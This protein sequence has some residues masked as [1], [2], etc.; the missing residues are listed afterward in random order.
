M[1]IYNASMYAC[2]YNYVSCQAC[3]YLC[4]IMRFHYYNVI[5]LFSELPFFLNS[6]ISKIMEIGKFGI[7][8]LQKVRNSMFQEMWKFQK[9]GILLFLEYHYFCFGIA[10]L[11][12]M[13]LCMYI[14]T[15]I[16][17]YWFI[18]VCLDT[19]TYRCMHMYAFI[20]IYVSTH[21][22]ACLICVYM[23]IC[24]HVLHMYMNVC[25]M[26]MYILTHIHSSMPVY[27]HTHMSVHAYVC[28]VCVYTYTCIYACI[29]MYV[30][31]VSMCV[32]YV[33]MYIKE[34][35]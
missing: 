16:H 3:M 6:A 17:T 23:Y 29:H 20:S 2:K 25:N 35:I 32:M 11:W 1:N 19:Y 18:H 28:N 5:L 30:C 13:Y 4:T 31:I 21:P 22:Y 8:D 12:Y 7:Q 26:L 33:C 14:Y 24:M 15:H 34:E 10:C 9:W 27:T